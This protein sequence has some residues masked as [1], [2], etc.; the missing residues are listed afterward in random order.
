[1]N[2]SGNLLTPSQR[3]RNKISNSLEAVFF[4]KEDSVEFVAGPGDNIIVTSI[5]EPPEVELVVHQHGM[6][7][8]FADRFVL[9]GYLFDKL[10]HTV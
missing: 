6:D 3:L 4:G 10:K 8:N 1:M 7:S 5:G 9:A 2:V